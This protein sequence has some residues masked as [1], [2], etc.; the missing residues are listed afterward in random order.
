MHSN[1]TKHK[2]KREEKI[3]KKQNHTS[4]NIKK[5]NKKNCA[6][7]PFKYLLTSS[8]K[9]L[10]HWAGMTV[11]WVIFPH[12]MPIFSRPK[13]C[14][15]TL[16]TQVTRAGVEESTFHCH[17]SSGRCSLSHHTQNGCKFSWSTHIVAAI[18]SLYID[19]MIYKCIMP[20]L[21]EW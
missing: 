5:K 21:Y 10:C 15:C 7:F 9:S 4:Q 20:S 13:P 11:F 18:L 3:R 14:T 17:P 8:S 6:H 19:I 1:L 16:M 12:K 2:C